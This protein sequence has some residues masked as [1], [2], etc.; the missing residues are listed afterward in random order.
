M[1]SQVVKS[2]NMC[3]L[4]TSFKTTWKMTHSLPKQNQL[5]KHFHLFAFQQI[6]CFPIWTITL[7]FA[8]KYS[9]WLVML[10]SEWIVVPS[11]RFF[12][13]TYLLYLGIPS[14]LRNFEE[15]AHYFHLF[16]LFCVLLAFRRG[17]LSNVKLTVVVVTVFVQVSEYTLLYS[18]QS[19][20]RILA[21]DTFHVFI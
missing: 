7:L 6:A 1:L 15:N 14:K 12:F 17:L 18:C 10:G 11:T 19:L 9:T 5:I 8:L 3:P 2:L 13:P 16:S 21:H 20:V 4:N